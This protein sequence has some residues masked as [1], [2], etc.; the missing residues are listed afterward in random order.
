[1]AYKR[2][3]WQQ[4][5]EDKQGLPKVIRLEPTFPCG[6]AL[7]G[8]GAHP[9][10]TVAIVQPRM[11]KEVMDRVPYGKV[12]TLRELCEVLARDQ[13][14]MFSCTLTTGIQVM[15]VAQATFEAGGDTPY[16]RTLKMGGALNPKY[17]GGQEDQ[18]RRLEAEGHKV[19]ERGGRM[20]VE[21]FRDH[22]VE[23]P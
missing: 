5:M 22:L 1:M 3:T 13:E 18:R 6:K 2:K 16:W 11:V 12:I 21:D 4:K 15:V 10:D 14:A 8:L 23:K 19:A 20:A 17:P 7:M 9:G